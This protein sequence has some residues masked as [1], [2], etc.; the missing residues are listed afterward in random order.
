MAITSF[1][2][3]QPYTERWLSL[4]TVFAADVVTGATGPTAAA[5]A[6]NSNAGAITGEINLVTG[7]NDP[8]AGVLNLYVKIWPGWTGGTNAATIAVW[9]KVYGTTDWVFMETLTVNKPFGQ[10]FTISP[11]PPGIYRL[12]VPTLTD[13]A[14]M[15]IWRQHSS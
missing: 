7:I 1:G 15:K 8:V 9:C 2:R 4:P 11:A 6:G 5:D 12:G 14:H 10:F 3:R 13:G